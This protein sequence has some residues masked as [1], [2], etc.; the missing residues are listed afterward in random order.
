MSTCSNCNVVLLYYF[1]LN[2]VICCVIAWTFSST[3]KS[4]GGITL[5]PITLRRFM[6]YLNSGNLIRLLC[7][8][9]D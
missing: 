3:P 4:L 9:N 2:V 6:C 7:A 5:M 8:Q 1:S